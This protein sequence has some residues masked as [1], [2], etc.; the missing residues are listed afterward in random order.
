M[1][2]AFLF[3]SLVIC[4][5]A[6]AADRVY[7]V[8][9]VQGT[10]TLDG[11]LDEPAWAGAALA[12]QYIPV[13]G[14]DIQRTRLKMLHEGANLYIG[15]EVFEDN[16]GGLSLT[17]GEGEPTWRDDSLEIFLMSEAG[18]T[19]NKRYSGKV[20]YRVAVNAVGKRSDTNVTA[21]VSRML[22]DDGQE[23]VGYIIELR[24]PM[25]LFGVDASATR[26]L[27]NVARNTHTRPEVRASSWAMLQRHF[28]EPMNFAEFQLM[29]KPA[30]G[31]TLAL[32]NRYVN[33]AYSTRVMFEARN[34]LRE[35][36]RLLRLV[37]RFP[38]SDKESTAIAEEWSRKRGEAE[39]YARYFE[40]FSVR[41]AGPALW[42]PTPDT[43]P[44]EAPCP[45]PVGY[46]SP[47]A[48]SE[49]ERDVEMRGLLN[50][51]MK[52]E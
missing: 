42:Q 33:L 16:M 45:S 11:K 34:R 2:I 52:A 4:L 21:G 23:E 5:I 46:L 40:H 50:D 26:F 20:Y 31:E 28:N 35:Y 41:L 9:P 30:D 14:E 19:G 48:L 3:M 24:I 25:S 10:V 29:R 18:R 7:P 47:L 44:A 43:M 49:Q 39:L 12:D 13:A 1:F 15:G 22:A 51:L 38:P 27:G 36:G 37:E 6:H 8:Y 17:H 32:I